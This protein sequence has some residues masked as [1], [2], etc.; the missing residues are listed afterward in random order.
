MVGEGNGWCRA[1]GIWKAVGIAFLQ[2]TEE[3]VEDC[4][5]GCL[6]GNEEKDGCTAVFEEEG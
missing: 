2:D 5:E 3:F 4:W 6:W 1:F